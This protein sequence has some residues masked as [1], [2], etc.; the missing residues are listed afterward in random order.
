MTL[1]I[2]LDSF[3]K[4]A[5]YFKFKPLIFSFNNFKKSFMNLNSDLSLERPSLVAQSSGHMF[6]VFIDTTSCV[7]LYLFQKQKTLVTKSKGNYQI[8]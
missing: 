4:P 5:V 1:L 3:L 2:Q 8:K 6:S 7:T